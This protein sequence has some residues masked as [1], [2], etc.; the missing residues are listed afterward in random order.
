MLDLLAHRGRERAIWVGHDWGSP[1]VWSPASHHPQ[2]SQ[3]LAIEVTNAWPP[4][5]LVL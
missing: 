2:R 4:D 5:V 1:V 3:G